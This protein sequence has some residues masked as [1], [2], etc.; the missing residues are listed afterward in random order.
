MTR[1]TI[2]EMKYSTMTMELHWTGLNEWWCGTLPSRYYMMSSITGIEEKRSYMAYRHTHTHN[3][4]CVTDPLARSCGSRTLRQ[5]SYESW[6]E[7][8]RLPWRPHTKDECSALQIR[9]QQP[10]APPHCSLL[11]EAVTPTTA[12]P[13][14]K[15][16][17]PT[18]TPDTDCRKPLILSFI[19]AFSSSTNM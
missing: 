18:M 17:S 12:N 8:G 3:P 11:W 16:L 13:Q 9:L 6:V 5:K 7:L 2:L 1:W 10:T 4:R 14:V 19:S 15:D